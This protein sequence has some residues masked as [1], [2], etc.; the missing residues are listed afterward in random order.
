M[1][2]PAHSD[3]ERRKL[4]TDEDL[5]ICDGCDCAKLCETDDAGNTTCEDCREENEE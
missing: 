2:H 4:R 3:R 1:T 5:R